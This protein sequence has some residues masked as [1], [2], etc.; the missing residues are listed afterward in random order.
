MDTAQRM[1]DEAAEAAMAKSKIRDEDGK[2]LKVYHGSEE[3]F[4]VFDR[5][6]GRANM[7]IQGMFFS[8]WEEDAGGYG[9]NVRSFYL[10]IRNPA[11]EGVGYRALNRHKGQNQ[12]GV[13]AREDLER[14]GY[15]GVNKS[16][17]EYIAF[18]PEQIKLADAVTYD[19]DGKIIPISQRFNPENPDIRYSLRDFSQMSDREIVGEV[20][21]LR[22]LT[23]TEKDYIKSYKNAYWQGKNLQEE[24]GRR[25]RGTAGRAYGHLTKKFDEI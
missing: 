2:L 21:D 22:N 6:K 5:T 1:V 24:I 7:D 18:R 11:P 25:E 16:D 8:P 13:K 10:D 14:M 17:E 4:T 9:G 3:D 12:A 19:D 15:D 20:M 23:P